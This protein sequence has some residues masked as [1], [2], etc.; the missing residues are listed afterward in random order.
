MKQ[1]NLIQAVGQIDEH[2]VNEYDSYRKR[3]GRPAWQI[4]LI[5]AACFCLIA[6]GGVLGALRLGLINFGASSGNSGSNEESSDYMF[7]T[8]PVFPLSLYE[9]EENLQVRRKITYDFSPYQDRIEYYETTEDGQTVEKQYTIY[10]RESLITDSYYLENKGN[11]TISTTVVYPFVSSLNGLEKNRPQLSVNG[12]NFE[13]GLEFGPYSG[14]FTGVWTTGPFS[15]NRDGELLNLDYISNWQE[16]KALLSDGKYRQAAFADPPQLDQQV[17]VYEFTDMEIV[18]GEGS[19]PTLGVHYSTGKNSTVLSYGF[20]GMSSKGDNQFIQ[21][22][23][24]PE[25]YRKQFKNTFWLIVIG[26][27]IEEIQLQGYK[28]GALE[29]GNEMEISARITRREADLEATLKT[30]LTDYYSLFSEEVTPPETEIFSNHYNASVELLLS[31]GVLSATPVERYDLGWLVD[32]F[33]EAGNYDRVMY[34][35]ADIEIPAG[36]TVEISAYMTKKGS[37]DF[38][39]QNKRD[40]DIEAYEMVT[41]LGSNLNFGEQNAEIKDYGLLEIVRQN[42]GFDLEN[43]IRSVSLDLDQEHYYLKV[44]KIKAGN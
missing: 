39:C 19:N 40:A 28:N 36:S 25:E 8:G 6:A 13:T 21:S 18:A 44:R 42:F 37:H 29:K 33:S 2:L 41:R 3:P 7:Y 4:A 22:F 43:G 38:Y 24:L 5:T 1:D 32:V 26:D 9:D 15:G 11:E 30:L 23:S 12:E 35:T 31:Y 10:D 27:D 14:S 17:I 20:H 34:L 16:Y